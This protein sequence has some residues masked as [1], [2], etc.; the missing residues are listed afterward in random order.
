MMGLLGDKKVISLILNEMHKPKEA[1]VPQ[2]LEGD[3]SKAHDA[4]AKELIEGIKNGEPGKVS[5]SLKQF[6]QMCEKEEEYSDV[7]GE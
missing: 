5:R 1:E 3:F 6:I 2:G 7:E 4:I